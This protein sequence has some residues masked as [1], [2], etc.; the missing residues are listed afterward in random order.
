MIYTVTLNPALDCVMHIDTLTFGAIN[1]SDTQQMYFG[2]KGVNVSQMLHNLGRE[3]VATGF[4]AGF[5]GHAM[6]EAL[7]ARRLDNDF[8]DLPHGATRINVKLKGTAGQHPDEAM[9][10][11]INAKGPA[12]DDAAL[13]A[14]L[15]KLDRVA[16]GDVVI[17]SGN[18]PPQA[19]TDIYARIMDA[20]SDRDVA[21]VVDT[22]GT[23]FAPTLPH[24]P[25]LV[26][27][28]DEELEA[29]AG[30]PLPTVADLVEAARGLQHQGARNVLVS[31]GSHGALL[32]DE[33][34]AVIAEDAH[35]G[36][37]VSTVGAGD[38]TVAG[39]VHATLL[40]R[41]QGITGVEASKL[42]LH[43]ANACGAASAFTLQMASKDAVERLLSDGI[44]PVVID[45][46]GHEHTG[47]SD[48]AGA[49]PI[50]SPP[51]GRS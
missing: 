2:G 47:R 21:V 24:R 29:L 16:E 50:A 36:T 12:V 34:G 43:W 51:D 22:S 15:D 17:L 8:V 11:A 30:R 37:P 23:A 41:E 5:I 4:V 40:A 32:V 49:Q 18:L 25:F 45:D 19:P 20:L 44:E 35:T 13:Q 33:R 48:A 3:S 27:P 10:T 28:N 38:S 26:K 9:E 7:D 39:F 14:L 6:V 42:A 31:R 46:G 1:R